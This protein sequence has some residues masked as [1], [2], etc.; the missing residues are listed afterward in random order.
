VNSP[1]LK[2]K[3]IGA[4]RIAQGGDECVE[5]A[6]HSN[7]PALVKTQDFAPLRKKDLAVFY[8]QFQVLRSEPIFID[9]YE[10]TPFPTPSRFRDFFAVNK[11]PMWVMGPLASPLAYFVL[12][13]FQREHDLANL[14]FVYFAGY[15]APG[16]AA[17]RH[18]WDFVRGR[19][20][21]H[22]LTRI[23]SFTIAPSAEKQRLLE[24]LGF[25]QEGVLREHHFHNGRLHDVVVQAWMAEGRDV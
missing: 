2:S 15:P 11:R 22:G 4:R 25:R 24:S 16:S 13:D 5:T 7:S 23:Q 3:G 12:H 9:I 21:D 6:V 1:V 14:D 18:F 17:A 19:L 8:R 20:A 10:P